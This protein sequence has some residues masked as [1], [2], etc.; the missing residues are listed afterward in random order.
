MRQRY[1]ELLAAGSSRY[2][3]N[4]ISPVWIGY[5]DCIF[6]LENSNVCLQCV[7]F[8]TYNAKKKLGLY[9]NYVELYCYGFNIMDFVLVL[10]FIK[11]HFLYVM[12]VCEET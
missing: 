7:C 1:W 6:I 3:S 2:F 10:F 11:K 8:I 4:Q 5:F 12:N 9:Y